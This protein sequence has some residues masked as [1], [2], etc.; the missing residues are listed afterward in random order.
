MSERVAILGASDHSA[1][2]SYKAQ[3]ALI[4]AGYTPI[5]VNPRL[6]EVEGVTCYPDLSAC[7][8][9]I[10]TVTVYVR[11]EILTGLVD[12][13]LQAAPRRV[14]L[15]PGSEDQAVTA[16]LQAAGIRVEV[17]CTLILLS[18]NRF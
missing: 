4:E 7:P 14:I 17:A 8:G 2:F 18:G 1:R 5:L 12:S 13:I 10:D 11:P 3:K 6:T 16:R 15:N 9:P